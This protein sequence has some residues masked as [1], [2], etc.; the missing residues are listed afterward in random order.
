MSVVPLL[1]FCSLLLAAAGVG[2][3]LYSVRNRE[4]EHMDRLSLLPL[5]DDANSKDLP[6]E[7]SFP[8]TGE[9]SLPSEDAENS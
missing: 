5:E 2:M 7:T 3:F 1:V 9:V 8:E 4:P 6:P